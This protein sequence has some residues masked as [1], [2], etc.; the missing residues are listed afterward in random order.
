MSYS[1]SNLFIIPAFSLEK[2][3]IFIFNKPV[4][5]PSVCACIGLSITFLVNKSPPKPLI[6]ATANFAGA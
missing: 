6:E 3:S 1:E 4:H 5:R 2:K